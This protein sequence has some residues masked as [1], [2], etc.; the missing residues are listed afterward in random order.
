MISEYVVDEG[1]INYV[2]HVKIKL[3]WDNFKRALL[4]TYVKQEQ[5]NPLIQVFS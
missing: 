1:N 5:N 2:I 4:Q 3:K